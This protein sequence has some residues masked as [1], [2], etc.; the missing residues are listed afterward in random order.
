ML[1]KIL[2][3]Y[4]DKVQWHTD[5]KIVVFESDDWGSS[6]MPDYA[7]YERLVK[8]V[9][10]LADDY[11]ARYDSLEQAEDLEQLFDV[12]RLFKDANGNTPV[13]TANAIMANPA[14][15]EIEASGFSEYY[16][17]PFYQSILAREGGE[18]TLNL[19]KQGVQEHLLHPQFH[20]REHLLVP[21]W[22]HELRAGN[23]EVVEGFKEA[24]YGVPMMSAVYTKRKN[25]QAAFDYSALGESEALQTDSIIKGMKIFKDFFGFTSDSFIASA[26]IWN[27]SIEKTLLSTGVRYLQGLP[28]QYEPKPGV[29]KYNRRFHYTGQKNKLGQIYLVRNVFFEPSYDPSFD[30]IREC[31]GRLDLAFRKKTPVIIGTHRVNFIGSIVAANRNFNLALFEQLLGAITKKWPDVEF[32]SSDQLGALMDKNI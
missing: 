10:K 32:M 5:R 28:V 11:Y 24:V 30:W 2:K 9:P 23:P 26:Y 1:K 14:F 6:R 15:K 19:W 22:M 8:R 7:T 13:I 17:E 4:A 18:A 20:G 3:A 16:Y 27:R 21:V 12:L 29:D 31:M 25:L